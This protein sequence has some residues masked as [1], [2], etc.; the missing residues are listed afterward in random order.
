MANHRVHLISNNFC[1]LRTI[2]CKIY[3]LYICLK[4]TENK[5]NIR[6]SH[7]SPINGSFWTNKLTYFCNFR[8]V[9]LVEQSKGKVTKY[10]RSIL[11][12]RG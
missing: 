11:I 3:E 8:N 4:T 2:V 5:Q 9:Q 7:K 1:Y 12:A 6:E 10:K